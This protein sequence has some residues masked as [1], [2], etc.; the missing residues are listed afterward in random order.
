MTDGQSFRRVGAALTALAGIAGVTL[1]GGCPGTLDDKEKFLNANTCPDIPAFFVATCTSSACHNATDKAGQLDL[2]SPDLA[3]RVNGVL[4]AGDCAGRGVL[5]DP[6]DPEG[7][8]L[9]FKLEPS[10]VCGSAMP[11]ATD[12]VT[13]Q[14]L[15]CVRA[16]IVSLGPGATTSGAGMGGGGVGG[17]GGAGAGGSG[18]A[19]AG[20]GGGGGI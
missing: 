18:G 3:S 13:E 4:S 1:L 19:A 6:A 12:P 16:W 5:A 7:S 8:V 20:G 15:A 2:E 10:P 17:A 9:F 14:Q 11:L